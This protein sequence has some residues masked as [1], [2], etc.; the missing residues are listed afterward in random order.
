MNAT[1][2]LL[3]SSK[4]AKYAHAPVWSASAWPRQNAER[5][6][7]G[8]ELVTDR[9]PMTNT[10]ARGKPPCPRCIRIV[11]H[12]AVWLINFA[13]AYAQLDWSREETAHEPV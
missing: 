2:W 7:C 12:H 10:L 1:N 9:F 6:A 8:L 5:T 13:E 3:V 4:R 11:R